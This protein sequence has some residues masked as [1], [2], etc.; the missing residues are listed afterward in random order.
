VS[1]APD[2]PIFGL[3]DAFKTAKRTYDL[4]IAEMARRNGRSLR[5]MAKTVQRA[6]ELNR[7]RI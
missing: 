2:D 1:V 5:S 7:E 6:K 3:F 4:A